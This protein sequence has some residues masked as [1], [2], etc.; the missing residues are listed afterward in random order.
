M[1]SAPSGASDSGQQREQRSVANTDTVTQAKDPMK[2]GTGRKTPPTAL[3]ANTRRRISMMSEPAA[4]T[5]QEAIDC[6]R[7]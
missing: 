5:T 6:E 1:K 7:R 2:T 4:V 3:P